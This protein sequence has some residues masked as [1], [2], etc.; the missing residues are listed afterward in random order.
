MFHAVMREDQQIAPQQLRSVIDDLDSQERRA[1]MLIPEPQFDEWLE[2][3]RGRVARLNGIRRRID[4]EPALRTFLATQ[5]KDSKKLESLIPMVSHATGTPIIDIIMAHTL[6]PAF[7]AVDRMDDHDYIEQQAS[8]KETKFPFSRQLRKQIW[9]CPKCIEDDLSARHKRYF[10]YWRRSHQLSGQLFCPV[11]GCGLRSSDRD[12]FVSEFPHELVAESV[13]PCSKLVAEVR[14]TDHVALAMEISNAILEG[15]FS[16]SREHCREV[17]ASR[18]ESLGL[19]AD[20][21]GRFPEVKARV[22]QFIPMSWLRHTMPH[23]MAARLE[24]LEFVDHVFDETG[25]SGTAIAVVA[26]VL[27]DD[28]AAA[29]R[30]LGAK[31]M[32]RKSSNK[33]R[34]TS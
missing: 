4:I 7:C 9:L 23:I 12:D 31:A 6:W 33:N 2:G 30:A 3:Y 14:R 24:S 21:Q 32:P 10:S 8:G 5:V 1:M 11:H 27:F 17:L 29:L 26:S 15:R 28:A 22:R 34:R 18:A 13:L 19:E 25:L 16:P 20:S